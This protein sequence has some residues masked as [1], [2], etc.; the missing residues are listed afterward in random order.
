M[1]KI[2]TVIAL[3]TAFF[4]SPALAMVEVGQA[5]PDF[6]AVDINEN[7]QTLSQYKDKIVVLEWNN[8]GCP[9]VVKHY[10]SKNMQ[11]L[12]QYATTNDVVWLTINSSAPGKQGNMSTEEA[13]SLFKEQGLYS[14]AYIL[15]QDG[16][17]G[18][19][20]GASTTPH[21]FVIDPMGNIAYAGA[22]DDKPTFDQA[23]IEGANNYVK[24]AVDSL[25]A[26]EEIETAST[27]AYGCSV[28][29]AN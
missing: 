7:E 18:K 15:D 21:M 5:A 28:K 16:T 27:E 25:L 17:I 22:I 24:M 13:Q 11:N 8:P 23:D 29:Y 9:F 10:E 26:R 1:K 20:Y 19:L 12:Q 2:T 6:I 3:I 14:T 4:V